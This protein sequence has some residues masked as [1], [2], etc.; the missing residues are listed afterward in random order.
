[1]TEATTTLTRAAAQDRRQAHIGQRLARL[2]TREQ[3]VAGLALG[4]RLQQFDGRL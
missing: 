3:Q 2:R 1:M 4:Q